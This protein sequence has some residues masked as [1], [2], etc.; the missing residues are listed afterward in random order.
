MGFPKQYFSNGSGIQTS[1]TAPGVLLPPGS[2]T[3]REGS[4][5]RLLSPGRGVWARA[6]P[7]STATESTAAAASF[8]GQGRDFMA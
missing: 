7:E 5:S 8:R 6:T 2:C 1:W 4:S 3:K